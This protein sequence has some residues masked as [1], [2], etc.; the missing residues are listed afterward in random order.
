MLAHARWFVDDPSRQ[1]ADWGFLADPATLAFVALVGAM[2]SLALAAA[3][4]LGRVPGPA[5]RVRGAWPARLLAVSVGLTLP[6]LSA[7][8]RL[9]LPS[10]PVSGSGLTVPLGVG[11]ALAGAWLLSGR[12]PRLA[13]AG[14]GALCVAAAVLAGPLALAEGAYMPAIAVCIATPRRVGAGR[15][16]AIAL[17]ASLVTAALTEKLAAPLVSLAVLEMHPGL[18]PLAAVG[19]ALPETAF[20]RAAG[21]VELVLGLLLLS[22]VGG[23][24]V[25]LV[26]AIPFAVT[27]PIFGFSELV[28][29]LPIYGALA[30]IAAS[31]PPTPDRP[32]RART[33]AFRMER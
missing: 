16:L 4:A 31:L 5:M 7:D 30:F 3:G 24:I 10:V 20:V 23:R 11:Q 9:L 32:S 25:I 29:H 22:G 18:D 17:G 2:G 12:R 21:A 6:F 13:A 28:G 8:E 19:L 27:V 26:A 15:L 14:L 1:P 33:A